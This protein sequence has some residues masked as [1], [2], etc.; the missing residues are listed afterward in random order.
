MGP[1]P[2]DEPLVCH[3]P[4]HCEWGP[5]HPVFSCD[6]CNSLACYCDGREDDALCQ[7]CWMLLKS[8]GWTDGDV[9]AAWPVE[10]SS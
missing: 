2:R 10:S 3:R 1:D 9:A 4:A 6:R 7:A 8:E 5:E